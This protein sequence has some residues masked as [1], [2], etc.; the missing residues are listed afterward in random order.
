LDLSIA[1]QASTAIGSRRLRLGANE[2]WDT[3]AALRI[4]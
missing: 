1:E 4:N 2:V 3:L